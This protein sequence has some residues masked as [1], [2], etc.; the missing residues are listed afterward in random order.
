MRYIASVNLV[1]RDLA[2]RNCLVS[3]GL[4]IKIGDFGLSR[5]LYDS[6]YYR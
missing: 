4:I 6:D 2:A 5:N 3:T 1:H